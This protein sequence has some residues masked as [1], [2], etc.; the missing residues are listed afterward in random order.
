M[1]SQLQE[2]DGDK[3]AYLPTDVSQ[4]M[5]IEVFQRGPESTSLIHRRDATF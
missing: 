2:T 3:L 4:G 1:K 5:V